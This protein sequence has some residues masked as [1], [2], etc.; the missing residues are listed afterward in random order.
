MAP[1]G[2]AAP[3]TTAS[4]VKL[5]KS[6]TSF[7]MPYTVHTRKH[8]KNAVDAWEMRKQ[9]LNSFINNVQWSVGESGKGQLERCAEI[10]LYTYLAGRFLQQEK[11]E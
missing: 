4:Q 9:A 1:S 6:T 2:V 3:A 10:G 7:F 5:K 11:L 8:I